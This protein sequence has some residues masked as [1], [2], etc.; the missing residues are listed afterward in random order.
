[1][2]STILTVFNC[3]LVI[4]AFGCLVKVGIT[5]YCVGRRY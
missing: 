3:V 5:W 2:D 1:M 4:G